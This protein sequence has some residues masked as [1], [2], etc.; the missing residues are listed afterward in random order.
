MLS[1]NVIRG[2]VELRAILSGNGM[3]GFHGGLQVSIRESHCKSSD[4]LE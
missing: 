2:S 4:A 3:A 1:G